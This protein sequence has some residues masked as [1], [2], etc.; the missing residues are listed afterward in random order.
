M[1]I[2][3]IIAVAYLLSYWI[4]SDPRL[5]AI[6]AMEKLPEYAD[7]IEGNIMFERNVALL[8]VVHIYSNNGFVQNYMNVRIDTDWGVHNNQLVP[9]GRP[10]D[11]RAYLNVELNQARQVVP[12]QLYHFKI[13]GFSE[14][15]LDKK[16]RLLPTTKNAKIVFQ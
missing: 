14:I 15:A 2:L 6:I 13:C 5:D 1:S 4:S 11:Q 3:G 12:H 9:I 7:C 16:T 8:M 10:S